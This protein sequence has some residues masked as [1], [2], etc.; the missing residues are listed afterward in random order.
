MPQVSEQTPRFA[1][2]IPK[3]EP[4]A[5]TVRRILLNLRQATGYLECWDVEPVEGEMSRE[6]QVLMLLSMTHHVLAD[7]LRQILVLH[8]ELRNHV[9][10]SALEF[11][12]RNAREVRV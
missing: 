1:R 9:T 8:A 10:G 6:D 3:G 7:S 2:A 11:R 4:P 12:Q 5:E